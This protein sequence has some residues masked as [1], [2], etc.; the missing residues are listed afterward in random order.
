MMVY[1]NFWKHVIY[2]TNKCIFFVFFDQKTTWTLL[3]QYFINLNNFWKTKNKCSCD[4]FVKFCLQ[5]MTFPMN[6]G[7]V[8]S[9][10]IFF[11]PTAPVVWCT[12]GGK[13]LG[14]DPNLTFWV[15]I[16]LLTK[17]HACALKGSEE[18]I[19]TSLSLIDLQLT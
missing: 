16:I 9:K 17:F 13:I 3:F 11:Y 15:L 2:V 10:I 8:K 1:N 12:F 19:Q 6:Y 18:H 4:V 5:N 7:K 14:F